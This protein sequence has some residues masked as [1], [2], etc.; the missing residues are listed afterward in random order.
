ML[1]TASF[2]ATAR[3]WRTRDW[4]RVRELAGHEGRVSAVDFTPDG[5][6]LVTCALD[7]T[8]KVWAHEAEF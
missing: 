8:V 3:V 1:A 2:D 5:S 6:R 7:R 4:V